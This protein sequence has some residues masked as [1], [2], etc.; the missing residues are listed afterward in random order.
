MRTIQIKIPED[1]DFKGHDFLMI[2]ASKLY[3]EAKIS[4][5]QAAQ[6]LGLTKRTFLEL[7]G[8]YKISVFSTSINDLH[9]DIANS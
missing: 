6:M 2:I 1:I 5:G 7:L 8:K 4:S 9:S 3:E